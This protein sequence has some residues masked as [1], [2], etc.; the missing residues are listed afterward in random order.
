MSAKARCTL[1]GIRLSVGLGV[2]G[3]LLLFGAARV[4]ATEPPPDGTYLVSFPQRGTEQWTVTSTCGS[5]C[6]HIDSSNS[7]SADARFSGSSW[8]FARPGPS[9]AICPDGT[10]VAGAAIY[11]FNFG[12]LT[13]TRT[14]SF[15]RWA[16]CNGH[17][18][19]EGQPLPPPITFTMTKLS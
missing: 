5:E 18:G 14:S 7:L 4:A 3:P 13:G 9:A 1:R 11:S 15:T 16:D 12:T 8:S 10:T 17:P 19:E 2:A 6:V